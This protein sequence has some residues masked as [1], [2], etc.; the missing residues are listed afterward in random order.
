MNLFRSPQGWIN[1]MDISLYYYGVRIFLEAIEKGAPFFQSKALKH[2]PIFEIKKDAP[3]NR[4]VAWD[5][6][7]AVE[8]ELDDAFAF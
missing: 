5:L 6:A 1:K 2:A 3:S 7:E 4:H 8:N